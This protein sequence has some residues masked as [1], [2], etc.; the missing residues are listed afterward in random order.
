MESTKELD[1]WLAYRRPNPHARLRLFCLPYAGGSASLFGT[2]SNHLP[3]Q[4]EVCPIQFP[5]RENRLTEAPYKRIT[6]LIDALLEALLPVFD[7][8]FAFFG[9]S[10]G[11]LIGFELARRLR[12][13]RLPQP[14]RLFVSGSSAPQIPDSKPVIHQLPDKEFIEAV[15][16]L[17]GTPDEI[18]QH[19]ELVQILLPYL[20]ADFE[21]CET[22]V[23]HP[24][25]PLSVPITVF[26]GW[27]DRRITPQRVGAW[28]DQTVKSC[29][30]RMF[31]GDHFF[32][33]SSREELLLI[34]SQELNLI[35]G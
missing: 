21:I 13:D 34:L 5:G 23:Y 29:V 18:W 35:S 7:K 15:R 28:R 33:H 9:H 26:G 24:E 14:T 32:L 22:Y 10:M 17:N 16:Q 8:P 20:R 27:H 3:A 2:W 25:D 19:E 6:L 12:Q 1:L 31:S 11:A 4:I 30:I